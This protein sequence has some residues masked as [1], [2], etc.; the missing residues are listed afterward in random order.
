MV[1][2]TDNTAG[3]WL[4]RFLEQKLPIVLEKRYPE[5]VFS[6]GRFLPENADLN[7]GADSV[8]VEMLSEYGEAAVE[9]DTDSIP[10]AEISVSEDRGKVVAVMAGYSYSLRE[11]DAS[12]QAA[13]NGQLATNLSERRMVRAVRMIEEKSHRLGAYGDSRRGLKGVLS[14]SS[15]PVANSTFNPYTSTSQ[16][17]A[18]DWFSSFVTDIR[19]DSELIESP[20]LA[21]VPEELYRK[22]ATTFRSANSDSTVLESILKANPSILSIQPYQ[23][24]RSANLEKYGVMAGGTNKDRMLIYNLNPENLFRRVSAIRSVP[25]QLRG[26]RYEGFF[27]KAVSDVMFEYP[28]SARYVDYPKAA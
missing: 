3:L 13:R 27:Y 21:L 1:F 25:L 11:A 28:L 9:G 5:L 26:L 17:D 2:T 18:I 15:V 24:G 22:W 4:S 16:Q 23:E 14:D 10:L 8:V 20:N 6:N 7:A 19:V 12:E